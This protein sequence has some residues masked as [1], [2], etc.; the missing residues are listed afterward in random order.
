MS[1]ELTF[2]KWDKDAVKELLE[3]HREELA[4]EDLLNL[5]SQQT[6]DWEEGDDQLS[7]RNNFAKRNRISTS[8]SAVT[9]ECT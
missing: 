3:T 7:E 5:E 4:T 6:L 1:H 9:E 2:D 8:S